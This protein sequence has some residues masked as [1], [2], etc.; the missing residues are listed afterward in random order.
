MAAT[1]HATQ[2]ESTVTSALKRR[3]EEAERILRTSTDFKHIRLVCV[4]FPFPE[5]KVVRLLSTRWMARLD[6]VLQ[7][8]RREPNDSH[9]DTW[10]NEGFKVHKAEEI[11]KS[12]KSEEPPSTRRDIVESLPSLDSAMEVG[13]MTYASQMAYASRIALAVDSRISTAFYNTPFSEVV[14][15]ALGLKPPAFQRLVDVASQLRTELS[16]LFRRLDQPSRMYE[17]VQQ[18]SLIEFQALHVILTF[19]TG[20]AISRPFG[21]LDLV[22]QPARRLT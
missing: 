9:R 20:T 11:L 3:E 5:H 7:C 2:S 6:S 12:L 17:L 1:P 15:A 18:A 13:Q 14:R 16:K 21:S 19:L 22:H 10:N 4:W 8:V